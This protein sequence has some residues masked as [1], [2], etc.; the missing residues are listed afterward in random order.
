MIKIAPSILSADFSKLGEEVLRLEQSGADWVH[1]DVMDGHFVPNLTFGAPVVTKIRPCTSLFF[2]CHLMVENPSSLLDDFIAAGADLI[3]VHIE[4]EKHMDRLVT[5]IKSKKNKKGEAVKAGI[6]LNP[7]TPLV[8]VEEL[9]CQADL[10]LLMSVNP[11]FANQKFIPSTLNKIKRLKTMLN[12]A[13]SKALI[14][15]DGGIN[16]D[17]CKDVI[18]A[19]A[20]VLVAGSAVFGSPN[21]KEAIK[22]LKA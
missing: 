13:G 17:T 21:I 10:I 12:K 20:D 3:T 7:S 9:L 2:D 11:G 5:A 1:I 19:G 22:L 6:S 18:A 14:Q 4:A 15:V 8:M 16:K